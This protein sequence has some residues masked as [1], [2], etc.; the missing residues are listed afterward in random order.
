MS[1]KKALAPLALVA[2][3]GIAACGD[4]DDDDSGSME[5]Q[6]SVSFVSPTNGET[7]GDSVTA[8]VELDGF[9]IDALNV[10]KVNEPNKGHLHFSLDGGKYD[11]PK[12]SG[13]N[14]EL[15]VQLGVEGMYSPATEPKITYSGLPAGEHTLEVH[16]VNNDHSETGT[17]ASTSFTVEGSGSAST[18]SVAVRDFEFSPVDTEVTAGDAV[19]WENEGDQTHTVKGDGFFS[20]AMNAGDTYKH[21]FQK[22]GSF[23]YVCTLHPQ[24]TGTVVVG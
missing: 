6:A 15:A 4:D 5:S 2:A 1:L 16:L 13:A 11:Y 21:T 17:T 24:M 18:G 3:L 10:G 23:D 12:Y 20:K 8:E 9:E 22:K 7:A 19:T 14:G